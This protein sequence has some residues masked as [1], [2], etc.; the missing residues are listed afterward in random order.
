M[1]LKNARIISFYGKRAILS[2]SSS[3][4]IP[5][6]NSYLVLVPE[7]GDDLPGKDPLLKEDKNPEF[8]TITVEK[9][10]AAIGK[11]SLDFENEV[12]TLGED[13]QNEANV[14]VESLFKNVLDPIEQL[15]ASLYITWGIAKI[16]YLGNQSVM[17]TQCYIGIHERAKRALASRNVNIPIYEACQ[18]IMY[19]KDIKLSSQQRMVLKKILLEAKLNGLDLGSRD[20][21]IHSE[22]TYALLRKCKEY[23]QKLQVATSQ[24]KFVIKDASTVKDFPEELLKSMVTDETQYTVGPWTVTLNPAIMKPFMEYCPDHSLRWKVWEADVIKASVL[25]DRMVQ[26]STLLEEIRYQRKRRAQL[27]GYKTYV[28][29]SMETK[30][31]G[32]VENVYHTL[33]TLLETARRAQE[34]ELKELTAFAKEKACERSLQHWDIPFWSKKLQLSRQKFKEEDFKQYF[35][36][37][38]VLSG[39]FEFIERLFG[40]KIVEAKKPDVW[41]NDVRFFDVYDLNESSTTPIGSFYLD[42][43]VRDDGKVRISHDSG[44]MVPLKNKSKASGTKPLV[45][46]I[47]NF[48]SPFGER[49]SL[50]SFKDVKTLFQKFGHMMQHICTKVDYSDISGHANVEWDAAFIS[51]YFF[52]NWLYE[53]LILQQISSHNDTGEPLS[54]EMIK[55]LKSSKS[56]LAG[57]N[58]CKELY[59]SRFDLEL[60][61]S[62]EFWNDIMNRIWSKHFVLPQHKVDCHI[63]SFETIFS[64][65]FAAAYYS[66]IWS[67]M[68]AADLFNAFEEKSSKNLTDETIQELGSRYRAT[69]MALGGSQPTSEVFRK[70]RGRDPNPKALLINMGFDVEASMLESNAKKQ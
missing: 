62:D 34:I 44:Y 12:K 32:N 13:L 54:A 27:L 31:A 42:P 49:P 4:K 46:L 33:D 63:C 15:Y 67:Q 6:R 24:Y 70:F 20:R 11:Q 48:Q 29:L 58:L 14:T 22:L 18:S 36:L 59:L 16:L 40:I 37:P 50:L 25:Q 38:K 69:F 3:L 68:V 35:P 43:Y 26:T 23:S 19:D 9:C 1:F 64:G 17:P 47:F 65:D 21:E 53:P 30:M 57:Y 41:H 61:S 7:I 2:S 52:E 10:I 8:N 66:T 28:D 60:H 51:D 39:T 5:K 45:A 56:H 55:M